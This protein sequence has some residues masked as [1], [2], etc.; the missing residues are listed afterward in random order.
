MSQPTPTGLY[1]HWD[2][3]SETGRF[4][5]R[6]NKTRSF[7]NMVMSNFQ[8]TRTGCQNKSFRSTGRRKKNDCFSVHGFCSQFNIVFEA[9]GCFYHFCACQHVRPSLIEEDMQRGRK[10]RELDALS[11]HYLQ[12]KGFN[13]IEMW[14]CEWCRLHKTTN[15]V[16][17]YFWEHFPYKLSFASEQH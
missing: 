8:R 6:Q 5:H 15:T 12:E 3:D 9:M 17:Q 10:N 14:E 13:V 1:T 7:D 4:T 11:G 2:L 16:K